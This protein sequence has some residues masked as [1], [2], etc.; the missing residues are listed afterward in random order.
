M[1]TKKTYFPRIIDSLFRK[2]SLL[3]V[4][5]SA[6]VL[7][8]MIAYGATVS[9]AWDAN[10]ESDLA[11]YKIYYGTTSGNYSQ[12]IDVGNTT[13]YTLTGL[14]E[15]VTYYIA[16]TAYDLD[17]N[18]SAYSVELV[19]TI[20]ITKDTT[21]PM[22][23]I[24]TP[25]SGSTYSTS[26]SQLSIGGTASD[27]VAVTLVSWTNSRGGSGTCSGTSSWSNSG[28]VLS[29][30][31]NVITVT[32]KDAAGNTGTDTLTVTYN[33]QT[34]SLKVS[35]TP[36]E[37]VT[38]G[39]QWRVDG[40]I[41]RNS[42]ATQS[43]LSIG[44]HTVEFKAL[45][46]WVKPG[47]KTET[48][49]YNQTTNAGGTYTRQTGSLKVS[50][51]PSEAVTAGAQWRVD[52]GIW[53][54]SGATQSGLSIGSHTVEFKALSGWAKPGNKTETINYNQT[55]N[56]GGTYTRQ[57]GSLKVSI[58]PS[59]AVT[60][61]AQWRVDGGIWRNSGA[62]QSGLSIG[63]HTV[64]FKALSGWA[65]PGNKTE[66]INYNQ[67]T[68]AGGTYT[69]QTGSL[70]VSITPSE[71]VTAGAQWR[72]DGGSWRNSGATQSGLSIGSHTVEFKALSGWVSRAIRPRP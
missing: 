43:G 3:T 6:L 28:I 60:A 15:N 71:A 38:A 56:A 35:I 31:Q 59:E 19:H 22:V 10:T 20:A 23:T 33:Q 37:A 41:W 57:T 69:Q 72:V 39:A 5:A 4:L 40:G 17:N 67:T 16:V 11:G 70:K 12:S 52:G 45:S 65:E 49:N 61:G 47:N 9:L 36:S 29:S 42:G 26:Q 51:T 8:P 58:T 44:S 14:A 13:E 27:N 24:T 55:T 30:G 2:V 32:A 46:G 63:S 25:T 66:T 68:N 50:I 7:F 18:E 64:E 1:N 62:T 48:I 53:R 54:N 34:G 21:L